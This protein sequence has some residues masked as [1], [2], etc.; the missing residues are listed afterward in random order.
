MCS[1]FFSVQLQS[2]LAATVELLVHV[3]ACQTIL[4][5]LGQMYMLLYA[6]ASRH[7]SL[8]SVLLCSQ[9]GC[10]MLFHLCTAM[11]NTLPLV[12]RSVCRS[13]QAIAYFCAY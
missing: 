4:K 11:A 9:C 12:G 5:S 1:Y 8:F 3:A 7:I 6:V 2:G 13:Y 10:S